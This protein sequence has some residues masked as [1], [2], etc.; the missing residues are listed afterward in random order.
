ML[1]YKKFTELLSKNN[2]SAYRVANETGLSS[3]LFS[4]WK[5][6]KSKPKIDKVKILADYFGVTIEYFIDDSAPQS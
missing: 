6:G 4:D 2:I 1:S 5:S 3:T